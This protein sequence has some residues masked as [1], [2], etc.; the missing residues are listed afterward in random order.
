[1]KGIYFTKNFNCLLGVLIASC[2]LF[3]SNSSLAQCTNGSSF[4]SAVA[5]TSGTANISGCSWQTEYS[6]IT[7]VVSGTTYQATN[8]SGGCITVH[9]GTPGGPVVAF[10]NAPLTWT[11]TTNGTHYLHYNTNC[12]TCAT[13]TSCGTTTIAYVSGGGGGG[14]P[15]DDIL[16]II[17]CGT[18]VS[19]TMTGTGDWNLTGCW[20]GGTPGVESIFSFTPTTS[21]IHSI[22][23]TSGPGG[24]VDFFWKPAS[25][26]CNNTGWTCIDDIGFTGNYGSMNWTA[27]ETYYILLDPEDTGANSVTFDINC[28]NPTGPVVA[29]DCDNSHSICTDVDFEIDP[30]GY[31]NVDELCTNCTSNPSTNP[32]SGNDGCLASGELNSTWFLVNVLTAGTL[33]FSFGEVPGAFPPF[34][35]Y[36]WIMWPYDENTCDNIL[37]NSIAPVRCNWNAPCEGFTGIGTP[38]PAGGDAGNFEP[39]L[40]VAANTQYIICFSNYSS[41]E[42]TLPLNF[43]GTADISCTP[44]PVELMSFYGVDLGGRNE[45]TWMTGSEFNSSYFDVERSYDAV[46]YTKIGTVEGAGTTLEESTYRFIDYEVGEEYTYYRLKQYDFDG[47]YKSS[48]VVVIA[49]DK[50]SQFRIVN[51][52]PNPTNN[53]F[54]VH[55]LLPESDNVQLVVTDMNGR[56]LVSMDSKFEKGV[57]E[58]E[59]PVVDFEDGLYMVT[60]I[61]E[62]TKEIEVIKLNV[63]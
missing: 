16:S 21:G 39:E 10:G 60:V 14:A 4:G 30:S 56:Q 49:Q 20:F 44:L 22:D 8:T 7:S 31:G 45:L 57:N 23:V 63:R 15:C 11:A 51:A 26:G 47:Q 41:V 2:F 43:F 36:D 29:G 6:T 17:G 61:N 28:P 55:L 27:G 58:I 42:T 37:G 1:M 48:N 32:A 12:T 9:S 52:F 5:P 38:V 62:R 3:A 50:N 59:I 54:N 19:S 25:A 24:Y 18:S 40:N 34:R 33:E 46:N 35:C 53:I 13:A